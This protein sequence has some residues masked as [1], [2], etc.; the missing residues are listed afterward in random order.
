MSIN[1]I[2]AIL[3]TVMLIAA[4]TGWLLLKDKTSQRKRTTGPEKSSQSKRALL[5]RFYHNRIQKKAHQVS[6]LDKAEKGELEAKPL[7][8]YQKYV[9][10]FV[11]L[12]A[13][14]PVI[15]IGKPT[16]VQPSRKLN[17]RKSLF[18]RCESTDILFENC[19]DI[20]KSSDVKNSLKYQP[21]YRNTIS[22]DE[23]SVK[24][25][26][27][28]TRPRVLGR[29][30]SVRCQTSNVARGS[31]ESL[32]KRTE[33]LSV[34]EGFDRR[35]PSLRSHIFR[36][37]L[38]NSGENWLQMGQSLYGR[39]RLSFGISY[40]CTFGVLNVTVNRLTGVHEVQI[41]ESLL[42]SQTQTAFTINLRLRDLDR[43]NVEQQ[44]KSEL[45]TTYTTHAVSTNLNPDFDQSFSF[46]LNAR[47]IGNIE[48]IFT[49]HKT[50]SAPLNSNDLANLQR[51]P[52]VVSQLTERRRSSIE[53]RQVGETQCL[54]VV[55]YKLDRDNLINRPD[56]LKEIWRDIQCI[57]DLEESSSDELQQSKQLIQSETFAQH[58]LTSDHGS[59]TEESATANP[60]V[61]LS[62]C[63]N[64]LTSHLTVGLENARNITPQKRDV[65]IFIRT[66]LHKGDKIL[67][68]NR[69]Q[70]QK[71]SS[72][73]GR[74]FGRMR[75][76]SGKP[77]PVASIF[78]DKS[79]MI[80][81]GETAQFP[82]NVQRML[83]GTTLGLIIYVCT[84]NRFGRTHLLGKCSIGADGFTE[85]EGC[86]HWEKLLNAIR[87]SQQ[88]ANS[89][90]TETLLHWHE[91]S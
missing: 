59:S 36:R 57:T 78:Q 1:I 28:I 52:S 4:I 86:I 54:G 24:A 20:S 73:Y 31:I 91:L 82:V 64:L 85:G 88:S 49:I 55:Q 23:T 89:E 71:I 21:S 12:T 81:K 26:S 74:E 11:K 72:L 9:S 25:G 15:G 58:L 27:S 35:T 7:N 47:D 19:S 43:K 68:A 10:G 37:S 46:R 34:D 17:R 84:R 45:G 48:L 90:P 32:A 65:S 53:Y 8:P 62:L 29:C 44:Q 50:T 76:G 33:R 63:Y 51:K 79:V 75:V 30:A 60:S 40:V 22:Q 5:A 67:A 66:V 6:E 83:E 61:E 87:K 41:M 14:K 69:S 18:A 2:L 77:K 39:G 80:L 38:R 13:D 56:S 16:L 42:P 70:S 3:L